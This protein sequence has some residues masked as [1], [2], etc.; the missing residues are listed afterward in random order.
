[1][2]QA[3]III[4]AI[5]VL[6]FIILALYYYFIKT[7][8]DKALLLVIFGVIFLIASVSNLLDLILPI[9]F[10][11]FFISIFSQ[12]LRKKQ[13]HQL[14]WSISL[15]MF[16]LTT[17]FQAIA[18]INNAWDLNMLRVY[19]VLASFQVMLLGLGELFL[20]SKR[21]V[22]TKNTNIVVV[23]ISGFF[24]ML[25]GFIYVSETNE[26]TFL[27]IAFLGL[28]LLVYGVLDIIFALL[29]AEKYQLTGFQY[30]NFLLVASVIIFV[31]SVY[32][33]FTINPVSGYNLNQSAVE[34]V[35]ASVWGSPSVV[36]AFAPI[37][38]VNGAMFIFIGSIYSYILWQYSIKK[39]EGKFTFSTGIFNI[40]FAIGVGIFTAGG[41]LSQFGGVT[42]L[43]ISELLGG[44]FMY[45]GFL[46][47]DKISMDMIL[48]IVTFRFLHKQYQESKTTSH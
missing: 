29:K 16:F 23:F 28:I 7:E 21:Y 25:F 8:S 10:L 37:F 36:R 45:F 35:I 31:L 14:I 18:S 15:L 47:S 9:L 12:Y 26:N 34:S 3:S 24:W 20:L 13:I 17:L 42:I 5:V 19:Y 27:L 41:T 46:E 2:D 43:Y 44:I 30:S 40:Y 33:T 4:T 39:K 48:D 11:L 22:I 38:T 1:M 6:L 32:F